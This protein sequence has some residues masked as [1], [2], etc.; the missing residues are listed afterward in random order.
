V[1]DVQRIE[2]EELDGDEEIEYKMGSAISIL[3]SRDAALDSLCSRAGHEYCG[4]NIVT[5]T[6]INSGSVFDCYVGSDPNI[7]RGTYS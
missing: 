7:Y 2:C 1:F 4:R 3:V 5:G 6:D